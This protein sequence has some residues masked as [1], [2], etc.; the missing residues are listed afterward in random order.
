MGR[1]VIMNRSP[2]SVPALWAATGACLLG[3]AG[4]PDQIQADAGQKKPPRPDAA[5]INKRSASRR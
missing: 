2:S 4:Q 3:I 1:T 5:F